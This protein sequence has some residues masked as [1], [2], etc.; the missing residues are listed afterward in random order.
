MSR[1]A[2]PHND[3][4]VHK[5]SNPVPDMLFGYNQTQAFTEAQQIQLGIL[6]DHMIA[7]QEKLVYPFFRSNLRRMVLLGPVGSG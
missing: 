2:A 7:T 6:N 1:R 5:I 4:F 3:Q